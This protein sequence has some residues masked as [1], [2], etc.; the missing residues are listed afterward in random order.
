M[1]RK[2]LS[3]ETF[4]FIEELVAQYDL[5]KNLTENDPLLK[6]KL[7]SAKTPEERRVIK[8]LKSQ[9]IKECLELKKP[10][11]EVSAA[12]AIAKAVEKLINKE[13]TFNELKE[14]LTSSLK[15]LNINPKTI[16]EVAKK[17]ADNENIEKD[18]TIEEKIE[19]EEYS[20]EEE[21]ETPKGIA[22]ELM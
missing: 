4:N 10:L 12:V 6:T 20:L 19:E 15:K 21:E 8:F 3:T 9:K 14:E 1:T 5:E 11:E 18:M 16:D 17:I 2:K 13:I 7:E 22:Q